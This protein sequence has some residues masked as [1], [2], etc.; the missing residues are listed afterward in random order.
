MAANRS[1]NVVEEEEETPLLPPIDS[2][3]WCRYVSIAVCP[4][5][6]DPFYMVA[7][8]FRLVKP[9]WIWNILFIV[10]G[11]KI[12]G[13]LICIGS[14]NSLQRVEWSLLQEVQMFP[15]LN[16]K[17]PAVSRTDIRITPTIIGTLT[18]SLLE[19]TLQLSLQK[20]H[21]GGWKNSAPW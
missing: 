6:V 13:K 15:K 7:Y 2:D 20:L 9:S 5:S 12:S 14:S 8:Y 17:P 11:D 4:R 3:S 10:R 21:T 1:N 19:S 18:W 16:I